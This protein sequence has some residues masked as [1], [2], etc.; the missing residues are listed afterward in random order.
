MKSAK[1]C[2]SDCI[3]VLPVQGEDFASSHCSFRGYTLSNFCPIKMD[4]TQEVQ[5]K[6]ATYH[7]RRHRRMPRPHWGRDGGA[8]RH[9]RRP[10][11]CLRH[12]QG[13]R[14]RHAYRERSSAGEIG[15]QV[16]PLGSR[17]ILWGF[18]TAPQKSN[19]LTQ[20]GGSQHF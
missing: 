1:C 6:N 13:G 9:G 11:D 8:D 10:S 14:P 3:D 7:L 17:L 18:L 5:Y 16:R 4:K 15:R 2:S 12:V 20:L 19:P